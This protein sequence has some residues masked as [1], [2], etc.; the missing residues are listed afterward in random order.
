MR[1]VD[2]IAKKRRGEAHTDAEIDFIISGYVDGG[3]PDYQMSAWMMAVCW[4][5]MIESEVSR[6][7]YAMMNSGDVVDLSGLSGVKVDKHSTGGVGDTTTLV[8]APLVAACGGTVAKMSG[9]GLGH[10]GGTLDKLESIP[11]CSID[12]SEEDFIRQV[13]KIGCAVI[14][15]TQDL[16]PADKALYA[17]RDV[18]GTV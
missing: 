7:T 18:T 13:Q 14:G 11:G 8:I 5:G 2:L 15:Q 12:V 3:I 9:R 4:Q 1:M 17:L 6:L 16:C 10:T